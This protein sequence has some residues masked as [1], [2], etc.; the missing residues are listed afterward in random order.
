MGNPYCSLALLLVISGTLFCM[1]AVAPEKT[2]ILGFLGGIVSPVKD[3]SEYNEEGRIRPR[4]KLWWND[5]ILPLS[6]DGW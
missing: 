5:I 2:A 1:V 3:A 4:E 6:R